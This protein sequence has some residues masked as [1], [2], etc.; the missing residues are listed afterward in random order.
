MTNIIEQTNTKET[1]KVKL[2]S[3]SLIIGLTLVYIVGLAHPMALH[4]AAHDV[5]HSSAFP[6]H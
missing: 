3:L 1:S 4:N 2:A 6:C 5:R